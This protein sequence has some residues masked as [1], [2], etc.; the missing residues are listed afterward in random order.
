MIS[1]KKNQ[2]A[3]KILHL[4]FQSFKAHLS[5]KVNHLSQF[6]CIKNV[7][8]IR[9]QKTNEIKCDMNI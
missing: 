9:L 4:S 6:M 7:W 8:H 3:I 2:F 1:E 5:G